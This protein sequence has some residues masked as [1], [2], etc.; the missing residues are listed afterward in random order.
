MSPSE[1]LELFGMLLEKG[2]CGCQDRRATHR[3]RKLFSTS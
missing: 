1:L 3:H 2:I